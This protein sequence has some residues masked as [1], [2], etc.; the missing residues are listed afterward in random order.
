[1]KCKV[2]IKTV[3]KN[4][5]LAQVDLVTLMG[6]RSQSTISSSLNRDMQISTFLRFLSAL[7]CKLTVTDTIT[8]EEYEITE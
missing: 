2:A 8:G 6:V 3:L 4:R 7:D 5:K 1:M